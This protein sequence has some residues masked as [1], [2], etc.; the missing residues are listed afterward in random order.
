MLSKRLV[1]SAV[2]C[3]LLAVGATA[4][5]GSSKDKSAAP[6][7]PASTSAKPSTSAVPAADADAEQLLEK[8]KAAMAGLTAQTLDGTVEKDGAK[9]TVHLAMDK[10]KNCT[11]TVTVPLEGGFEILRNEAGTWIK[12]DRTYWKTIATKNGS[13]KAGPVLAELF[14]GRYLAGAQDD[15]SVMGVTDEVCGW[16]GM[17]TQ[18]AGKPSRVVKGDVTTLL[19]PVRSVLLA[20]K[21]ESGSSSFYVAT[22]GEP[23]MV[24]MERSF[25]GHH[26]RLDFSDFNKPV[27]VTAPRAD[28]VVDYSEFQAKL[29]NP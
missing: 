11:G 4:C 20:A 24:R 1:R 28:E 7:T 12:P 17:F 22:E 3:V 21:D 5:G 10:K 29:K 2:V 6:P 23:Y 9:V 18:V 27:T 8:A 13:P 19:T 26:S 16:M 15:K 14:R 25:A